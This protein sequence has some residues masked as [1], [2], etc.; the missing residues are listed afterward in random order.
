MKKTAIFA[1]VAM[2]SLTVSSFAHAETSVDYRSN[3]SVE[4]VP[5]TDITPPVDPENPDPENPVTPIDPTDPEGPNPGTQGPLSIDYA[6]SLDFG[7][8]KIST[9]DETY[10]A[11]AQEL[12]DGRYVPNYVQVTDNRGT[13]AGWILQ[14]KQNGQLSNPDTQH[15]TL[16]GAV[17]EFSDSAVLGT[18]D[19][20]PPPSH[21]SSFTLDPDGATSLVLQAADGEGAGTWVNR[22]GEVDGDGTSNSAITL[23]VP[24]KTPKD[25]ATYST[26]LTWNLSDVPANK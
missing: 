4:F 26:T 7:I 16:T 24:G 9:K 21:S 12:S 14:V 17:I 25:Q 15:Q 6:S 5:N 20:V 11:K 3:G 8:N 18:Q 22:F 10:V 13:N 23:S 1:L 2:A 19:D